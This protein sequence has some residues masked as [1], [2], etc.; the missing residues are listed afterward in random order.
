[1]SSPYELLPGLSNG[2][3]KCFVFFFLRCRSVVFH[4]RFSAKWEFL[5]CGTL[6]CR[7]QMTCRRAFMPRSLWL[8]AARRASAVPPTWP[9][10]DMTTSPCSRN[11]NI[12]VAWGGW[13][14]LIITNCRD[15]GIELAVIRSVLYVRSLNVE[16]GNCNTLYLERQSWCLHNTSIRMTYCT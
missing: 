4:S 8:V 10:W 14:A 6:T 5:R 11:R 2:Y 1:M 12:S 16:G 7:L 13:A 3:W 9:D 15:L